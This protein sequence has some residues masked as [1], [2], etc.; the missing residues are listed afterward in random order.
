MLLT[1]SY[2]CLKQNIRMKL[3]IGDPDTFFEGSDPDTKSKSGNIRLAAMFANNTSQ[4]L[5]PTTSSK[6]SRSLTPYILSRL[7]RLDITISA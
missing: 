3:P 4:L 5:H 2:V 6:I 7:P 1:W